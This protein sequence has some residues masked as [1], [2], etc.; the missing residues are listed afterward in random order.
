MEIVQPR[1]CSIVGMT[2]RFRILRP[3]EQQDSI[4]R[5]LT[6]TPDM[7]ESIVRGFNATFSSFKPPVI[8]QHLDGDDHDRPEAEGQVVGLTIAKDGSLVAVLDNL[9]PSFFMGMN[10]DGDLASYLSPRILPPG[11]PNNAYPQEW[12]LSHLARVPIPA[13]PTLTIDPIA[14]SANSLE[15]INLAP[16][17]LI[18]LMLPK[19]DE[20]PITT[21]LETPTDSLE[22]VIT[23]PIEDEKPDPL[24]LQIGEIATQLESVIQVIATLTKQ[25]GGAAPR[26]EVVE[27][28]AKLDESL[29]Q[30]QRDRCHQQVSVLADN[31]AIPIGEVDE[32][33]EIL[34][35]MNTAQSAAYIKQLSLQTRGVAIGAPDTTG[36][37]NLSINPDDFAALREQRESAWMR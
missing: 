32:H 20:T 34:L 13:D 23:E 11:H 21:D 4:G 5:R 17:L 28:S 19:P 29:G 8:R 25:I 6:I 22:T 26:S 37:V 33:V 12:A 16:S 36:G 1:I 15:A 30:L 3:R 35:G 10:S 9:L 14:L 18:D 24:A 27:L 7:I 2:N 31:A